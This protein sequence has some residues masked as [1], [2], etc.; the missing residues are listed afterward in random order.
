MSDSAAAV[1]KQ[2]KIKSS[3]IQRLAKETKLYGTET[4]ALEAKKAKFIAD[5]A[6]EWDIKNA[7][8][9]VDESKKMVIDTKTRLDKAVEDLQALIASAK[10]EFNLA[11]DEAL[12]NAERIVQE[13]S[14]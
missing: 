9:M 3:A 2:L 6:E 10:E 12:L 11:E 7:T 13:A 8:K 1:Q 4:A 14:A 5:G